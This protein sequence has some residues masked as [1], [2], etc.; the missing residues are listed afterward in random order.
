[1]K[2]VRKVKGHREAEATHPATE[3]RVLLWPRR[4]KTWGTTVDGEG[5]QLGQQPPPANSGG[6]GDMSRTRPGR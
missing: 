4:A 6:W 5:Y 3:V 1:V 2:L